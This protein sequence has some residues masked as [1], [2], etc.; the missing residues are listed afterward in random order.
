MG[1]CDDHRFVKGMDTYN[2]VNKE[3][4]ITLGELISMESVC[5]CLKGYTRVM[6]WVIIAGAVGEDYAPAVPKPKEIN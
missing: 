1:S 4:Y 5:K 6:G 3:V 2:I